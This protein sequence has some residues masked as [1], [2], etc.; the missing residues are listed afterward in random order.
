MTPEQI[1]EQLR[2]LM[3]ELVRRVAAQRPDL[4]GTEFV[5]EVAAQAI[6][7]ATAVIRE[8]HPDTFDEDRV[9]EVGRQVYAEITD[10]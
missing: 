8:I 1:R 2:L 10:R 6:D 4:Y 5:R 9:R 3:A 7:L